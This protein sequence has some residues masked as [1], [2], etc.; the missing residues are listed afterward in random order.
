MKLGILLG[1]INILE[2]PPAGH[3]AWTMQ[4]TA[5]SGVDTR[6]DQF[7]GIKVLENDERE[8]GE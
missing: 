7:S 3:T 6:F 8:A 4:Q 5:L 2:S 1:L